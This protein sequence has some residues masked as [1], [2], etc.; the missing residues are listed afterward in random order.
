[1]SSFKKSIGTTAVLTP[2]VGVIMGFTWIIGEY[3]ATRLLD[4]IESRPSS[5]KKDEDMQS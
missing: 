4:L 2:L 5:E 3:F 1:M